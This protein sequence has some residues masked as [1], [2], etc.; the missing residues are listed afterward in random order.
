MEDLTATTLMYWASVGA[1][2]GFMV[3]LI[4]LMIAATQKSLENSVAIK[5]GI[6]TDFLGLAI[7]FVAGCFSAISV[8][9][10]IIGLI[11]HIVLS[12]FN[13]FV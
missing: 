10:L 12:I 8:V 11:W 3:L 2:G 9:F 5:G 7:A 1:V 4:G 6:D 13:A